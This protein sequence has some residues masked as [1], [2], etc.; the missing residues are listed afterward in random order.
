M[1]LMVASIIYSWE[2][3]ILSEC[4]ESIVYTFSDRQF[5]RGAGQ[6]CPIT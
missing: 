3:G 6:Y 2:Q 5:W 4:N 1:Q